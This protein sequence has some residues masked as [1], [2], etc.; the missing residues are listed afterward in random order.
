MLMVAA[1]CFRLWTAAQRSYPMP[2]PSARLASRSTMRC[3]LSCFGAFMAALLRCKRSFMLRGYSCLG[4]GFSAALAAF[5]AFWV[6]ASS[7]A[8]RSKSSPNFRA[9]IGFV[10]SG[11]RYDNLPRLSLT[12]TP[13]CNS[14]PEKSSKEIAEDRAVRITLRNRSLS[15]SN[16]VTLG[17]SPAAAREAL[18]LSSAACPF[19][20]AQYSRSVT[21]FLL[22]CNKSI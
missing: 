11:V 7:T 17:G 18:S 9:V 10:L 16:F 21:R 14:F 6:S 20:F 22:P 8:A 1:I 2:L 12:V 13:C 15:V 4:R 5:C 3:K 19:R